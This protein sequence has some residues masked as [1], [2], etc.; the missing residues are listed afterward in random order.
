MEKTPPK[1]SDGKLNCSHKLFFFLALVEKKREPKT[2]LAQSHM[3]KQHR[4]MVLKSPSAKTHVGA[5][6][7]NVILFFFVFHLPTSPQTPFAEGWGE[8]AAIRNGNKVYC[9]ITGT[10][11]LN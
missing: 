10:W 9:T 2:K 7:H 3:K 4:N 5:H 8:T 6:I 1:S 11:D